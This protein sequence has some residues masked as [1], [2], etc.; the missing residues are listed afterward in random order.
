M[1]TFLAVAAVAQAEESRQLAPKDDP[2]CDKKK[3]SKEYTKCLTP[4]LL[5]GEGKTLKQCTDIQKPKAEKCGL[6]VDKVDMEIDTGDAARLAL[7]ACRIARKTDCG[8]AYD[9][10]TG[11]AGKGDTFKHAL[12]AA[13][14]SLESVAEDMKLCAVEKKKK[15]KVKE[16]K[17][18]DALWAKVELL[19]GRK[20]SKGEYAAELREAGRLSV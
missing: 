11:R 6:K 18:K 15:D 20:I 14:G 9:T 13:K 7:T 10:T 16:K 1:I 3:L 12:Q 17:C 4:A 5:G 8:S 2:K 19:K